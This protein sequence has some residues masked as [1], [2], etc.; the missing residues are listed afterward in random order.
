M[1][2]NTA[3]MA[4]SMK[5]IVGS[6]QILGFQE[7]HTPGRRVAM[8][9]SILC[10][11]CAFSG[12]VANYT[13]DGS[14]AASLPIVWKKDLFSMVSTGSVTVSERINGVSPKFITWAK[15][16]DI[17]TGKNLYVLNT[18]TV[19]SV[20]SGGKPNQSNLTVVDMYADH[21]DI[22]VAK[23]NEF[24]AEKIPIFV[25]GDFNVNY[26]YDI[27][28]KTPIFPYAKLS[29]LGVHSNWEILNLAGIPST[30][31]TQGDSGTRLIDYVFAWVRSDIT[32]LSTS[33]G[34][35]QL[36]SDHYPV[37]Y[38]LTLAP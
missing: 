13:Y 35:S 15:L 21:M 16:R 26:R 14:S 12:Y 18:H 36:G 22:L 17:K 25:T 5:T 3:D 6:A 32:P 24:K 2:D 8:R 10:N 19:A 33:I 20:E 11:T 28:V 9:D 7:M 29:P 4:A 27:V 30:A 34:S 1:F 37:F 38:K 23:I 31:R